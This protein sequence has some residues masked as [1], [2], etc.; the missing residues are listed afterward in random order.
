MGEDQFIYIAIATG[1]GR[2]QGEVGR[3]PMGV[4]CSGAMGIDGVSRRVQEEPVQQGKKKQG[5]ILDCR[6]PAWRSQKTPMEFWL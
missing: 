5:W 4:C 6:L 1:K 3:L 2:G